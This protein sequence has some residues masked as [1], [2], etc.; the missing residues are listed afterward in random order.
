MLLDPSQILSVLQ[1][2]QA[3][4]QEQ[5]EAILAYLSQ[6]EKKLAAIESQRKKLLDLYLDGSFSKEILDEKL[7]YIIREEELYQDKKVDLEQRVSEMTFDDDQTEQIKV[8]CEM[9]AAGIELFGFEEQSMVI[10]TLD[11]RGIVHLGETYDDDVIVLTG[12]IPEIEVKK[13]D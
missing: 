1:E 12:Y 5:L 7:A 2:R 3:A 11:V 8:F 10:E 13:N 6:C 4:S 9:A